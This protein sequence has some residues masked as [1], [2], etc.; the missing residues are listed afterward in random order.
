[1]QQLSHITRRDALKAAGGLGAAAVGGAGLLASAGSA[2]ALSTNFNAAGPVVVTDDAGNVTEVH[3]APESRVEWTGFDVAVTKV[4]QLLEARL[5]DGDGNLLTPTLAEGDGGTAATAN[6]WWPVYRETPWLFE[7]DWDTSG[8]TDMSGIDVSDGGDFKY[9]SGG[10]ELPAALADGSNGAPWY[11]ASAAAGTSGHID[12]LLRKS[13]DPSNPDMHS[14]TPYTPTSPTVPNY[15]VHEDH[16]M[17]DYL[18]DFD[19]AYLTGVNIRGGQ[20]YVNG[21]YGTVGDTSDVDNPGDGSTRTTTV[22]L[23]LTTSLHTTWDFVEVNEDGHTEDF[24]APLVMGESD[25]VPVTFDQP[26]AITYDELRAGAAH[27]AIDVATTSFVVDAENAAADS[28]S[29]TNSNPG[30]S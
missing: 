17:P 1:M 12:Y 21:S 19:T 27:P 24:L 22:E 8:T 10:A 6:G 11:A 16:P 3:V 26:E 5:T 29:T 15:L 25:D 30:G 4:R 13:G 23:R 14:D 28:G 2:A 20:N 9:T 18:A 7:V